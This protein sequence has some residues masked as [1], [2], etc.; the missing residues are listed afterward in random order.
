ML[1]LSRK[2][3]ESIVIA[4]NIVI[5]VVEIGG[6]K[7]RLGISAPKDVTVHRQEI[8]DAIQ[9]GA[10]DQIASNKPAPKRKHLL[11]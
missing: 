9:A 5:T 6:N 1:V 10:P 8:Y 7:I 2:T 11:R 4:D 3:N